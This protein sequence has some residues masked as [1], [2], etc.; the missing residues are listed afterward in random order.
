MFDDL[1]HGD[2]IERFRLV[3]F[4]IE[5][6]HVDPVAVS[7]GDIPDV[8]IRLHAVDVATT[9][10]MIPQRLPVSASDVQDPNVPGDPSIRVG[11]F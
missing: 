3:E 9:R 10:P 5:E 4:R 6:T 7:L 1:V 8:L 11:K 2:E